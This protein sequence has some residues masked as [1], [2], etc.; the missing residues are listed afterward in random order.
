MAVDYRLARTGQELEVPHCQVCNGD[1][2]ALMHLDKSLKLWYLAVHCHG[3]RL[4][5]SRCTERAKG[6]GWLEPEVYQ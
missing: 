1:R 2:R 5:Y 4:H 3:I 6:V